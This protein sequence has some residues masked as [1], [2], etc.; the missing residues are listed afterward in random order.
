MSVSPASLVASQWRAVQAAASPREL[1]GLGQS[2]GV[3]F[4]PSL[5]LRAVQ[6]RFHRHL[7]PDAAPPAA[8]AVPTEP[9]VV[10]VLGAAA[11]PHVPPAPEPL[12]SPVAP[13]PDAVCAVTPSPSGA[14]ASLPRRGP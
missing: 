4:R 1:V 5:S 9:P 6:D 3:V 7:F 2:V 11:T 8:S 12:D 14:R 10:P 13:L